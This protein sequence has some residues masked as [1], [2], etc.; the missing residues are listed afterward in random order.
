MTTIRKPLRGVANLIAIDRRSSKPL[1]QQI[2]EEFRDRV[3]RRE[4]QSG[5]L[6][7]STRELSRDLRV[8]RLPVLEAYAQLLAEGYFEAR[9]GSGTFI[10]AS[11][12]VFS[13]T[14]QSAA[15]VR[16]PQKRPISRRAASLPKYERPSWAE[17]LGPFQV[18]QPDL[19]DFPMDVWSRLVG[20]YARSLRVKGLQ[21]GDPFG[22]PELR[23]AIATYLQ[24]S[25]AVR[26]TPEQIIIVS[27]SQQA[28]DLSARVLLDPDVPVWVEEPGYWLVHH[29]L[30]AADCRTMPVPVD[31]NGLDV[32]A[33]IK[34]CPNAR[35]AFVAPSHQYPLG[36]TM[37]AARRL[38]L[39]AWADAANAWIIEDDYDSEY[40]YDSAPIASLQG[41]D[42]N[43]RVIYIGNFS[44]VMFP[45]MRLGYLVVPPDM[46]ERF[47]AVRQ[48]MD[49]CPPHM[50]QAVMTEFIR[51]G[52]FSRH[53]RR[54]RPVYEERRRVLV[55]ALERELGN[56]CAIAGDAA[57]MHLAIYVDD[58]NDRS[59]AA[60]AGERGLW[61]SPLSASYAGGPTRTGFVLGYGNSRA[62][63][64][65]A[66]VT[67]L[68]KLLDDSAN[69][70]QTT[71]HPRRPTSSK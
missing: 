35:A 68:R 47:A 20:R 40:R 4:L 9:T 46:V 27:G 18:G 34:L 22:M 26:C 69:R 32:R 70:R 55:E 54:M 59:I 6:V 3:L 37:T 33:G 60:K 63:Q 45:S 25:R 51:E 67:Q 38:E 39:L 48:T 28:L 61:L 1:R 5:Q 7:P 15:P 64:I 21:Y 13:T 43:Q 31:A 29:V 50:N 12:Q 19:H 16:P 30:A 2:Y 56:C 49:I 41:L 42:R 52:H 58:C 14:P 65:P 62:A 10:A 17:S 8:S 53:L 44:K 23:R 71:R 24:A 66:A 57:G 36:V 11:L